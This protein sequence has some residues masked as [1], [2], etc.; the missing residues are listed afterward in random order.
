MAC[1]NEFLIS[2]HMP[3]YLRLSL[4]TTRKKSLL[5]L[6]EITYFFSLRNYRA[7]LD[8]LPVLCLESGA[9]CFFHN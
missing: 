1:F 4:E 2:L 3:F 6:Q 5:F 9:V 7:Y 8:L